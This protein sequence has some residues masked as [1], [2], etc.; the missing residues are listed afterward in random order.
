[1]K[2]KV[3]TIKIVFSIILLATSVFMPYS[4][5]AFSSTSEDSVPI[6]LSGAFGAGKQRSLT[7]DFVASVDANSIDIDYCKNYTNITI[8]ITNATAQTVYEKVVNPVAGESLVIDIS[9]W[10]EGSYYISFTN[11]S[12]D[13]I[14]GDFDIE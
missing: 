14:S 5:Y 13:C 6:D 3:K 10:A 1:M 2:T 4:S 8:E 12:G 11:T 7:A 9:D